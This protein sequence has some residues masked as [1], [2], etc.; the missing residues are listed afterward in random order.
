[1]LLIKLRSTRKGD[2]VREEIRVR[3]ISNGF[4]VDYEDD[5]I[6]RGNTIE[7]Y[8]KDIVSVNGRLVAYYEKR[9]KEQKAK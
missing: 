7:E 9:D 1:M 3:Q 8:H 5:A 2:K 6:G 4:I